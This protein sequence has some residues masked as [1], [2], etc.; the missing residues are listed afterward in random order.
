MSDIS[1]AKEGEECYTAKVGSTN[2]C[3]HANE[4]VEYLGKQYKGKELYDLLTNQ[5]L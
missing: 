2:I 4:I 1:M 5:K 3:F